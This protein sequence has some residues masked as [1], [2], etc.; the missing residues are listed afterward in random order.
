[1][2]NFYLIAGVELTTEVIY[3]D[4]HYYRRSEAIKAAERLAEEYDGKPI[5]KRVKES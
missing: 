3:E 4:W 5:L 1:M 2:A